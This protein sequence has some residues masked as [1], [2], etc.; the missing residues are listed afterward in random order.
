MKKERIYL[1]VP[2]E[3]KDEVKTLGAWW[4]PAE[5]R[6]FV[7]EGRDPKEFERWFMSGENLAS[8][9][10]AGKDRGGDAHKTHPF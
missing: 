5:K 10:Q 2:F 7:K 1:D 3:E 4:D 6:W 9:S 8:Y